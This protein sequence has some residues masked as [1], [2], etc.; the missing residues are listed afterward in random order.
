VAGDNKSGYL[1][2]D[3]SF[4]IV[5]DRIEYG[6]ELRAADLAIKV[7]AKSLQVN[8]CRMKKRFYYLKRFRGD[9][10]VRYKNVFEPSLSCKAGCIVCKFEVDS[11][12]CVGIG[13]AGTAIMTGCI[14]DSSGRDLFSQDY[15]SPVMRKLRDIGI[16]A[17]LAAEVASGSCDG[18]RVAAG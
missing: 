15:T 10:A 5:S 14:D 18:V 12:F 2:P 11:R 3:A 6:L 7:V 4:F 13:N 16:L 9:V 8:I 1:D 17:M